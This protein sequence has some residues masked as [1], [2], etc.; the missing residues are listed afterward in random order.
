MAGSL[1]GLAL[2]AICLGVAFVCRSRRKELTNSSESLDY[3]KEFGLPGSS[4]LPASKY[5]L[6][7]A[8]SPPLV[9]SASPSDFSQDSVFLSQKEELEATTEQQEQRLQQLQ[10]EVQHLQQDNIKVGDS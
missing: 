9:K 3:V 10:G 7:A 1:T 2:I 6:P 4:L 5:A 8:Y